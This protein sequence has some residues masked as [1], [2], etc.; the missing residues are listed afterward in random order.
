MIC[1]NQGMPKEGGKKE[2]LITTQTSK[3]RLDYEMKCEGKRGKERDY[4]YT[5]GNV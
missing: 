4:T 5:H 2:N 3:Q 1:E